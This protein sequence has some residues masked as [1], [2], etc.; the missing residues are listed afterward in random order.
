M[1]LY[2]LVKELE[3]LNRIY[4]TTRGLV[5]WAECDLIVEVTHNK[6]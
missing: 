1:N 3:G 5:I 4:F 2:F 6:N